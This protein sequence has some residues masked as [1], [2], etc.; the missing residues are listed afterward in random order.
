MTNK[1]KTAEDY[2]YSVELVKYG[3]NDSRYE[4]SFNDFP[5]VVG[6]G[7]TEEEAVKEAQGNLQAVLDD[8]ENEKMNPSDYFKAH[9][10]E[11]NQ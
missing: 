10:K 9:D 4:V 8:E 3:E 5:Y 11:K 7:A 6:E 2:P 1:K